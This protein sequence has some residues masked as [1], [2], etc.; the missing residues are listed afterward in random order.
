MSSAISDVLSRIS[1][2]GCSVPSVLRTSRWR[3]DRAQADRQ[4]GQHG[5]ADV[6][7]EQVDD[8]RQRVVAV[9]RVDRRQAQVAGQRVQQRVLHRLLV[10]DFA[11]HD[12]VGRLA[13]RVLQRHVVV[14]RVGADLALVDEAL[15]MLEQV[16]DRILDRQD[17]TGAI[18]CCGGRS[19]R[20]AWSTCRSRWRRR[21]APARAFPSR[22]RAAPAAASALRTPARC[23]ARSG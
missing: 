19:S 20:R 13:Q 7:R 21:R 3:H 14:V 15:L 17:V 8:P 6:V 18:A 2:A 11:D 5:R 10:A 22:G 9:V 4:V 23:C 16:L 1:T 12:E